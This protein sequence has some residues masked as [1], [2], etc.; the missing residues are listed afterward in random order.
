MLIFFD[1]TSC[2]SV[3]AG[4]LNHF[5]LRPQPADSRTDCSGQDTASMILFAPVAIKSALAARIA[6]EIISPVV[7]KTIIAPLFGTI[8]GIGAPPTPP[9]AD[10][11]DCHDI[12][13]EKTRIVRLHTRFETKILAWSMILEDFSFP[14]AEVVLRSLAYS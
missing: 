12:C 5:K 13:A 2:G 6:S 7:A 9:S 1:A 3:H 8:I 10:S 11:N 14:V 4:G